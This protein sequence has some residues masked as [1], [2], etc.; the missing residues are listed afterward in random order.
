MGLDCF[1]GVRYG[2]VPDV[3]LQIFSEG[4]CSDGKGFVAPGLV[5]TV[6]K[7]Q[8][9]EVHLLRDGEPVQFFLKDRSDAIMG[10]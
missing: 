7:Q 6:N 10:T 8:D 1:E 2:T 4:G 9:F 3:W 5:L